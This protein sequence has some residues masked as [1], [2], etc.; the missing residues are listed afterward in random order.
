M[1]VLYS[2]ENDPYFGPDVASMGLYDKSLDID[3]K[4]F[5]TLE[6]GGSRAYCGYYVENWYEYSP[7]AHGKL[8]NKADGTFTYTPNE[9][10]SGTDDSF[11]YSAEFFNCNDCYVEGVVTIVVGEPDLLVS[12]AN[13]L[14]SS[15][16]P[17]R[18]KKPPR[19]SDDVEEI[20]LAL[21]EAAAEQEESLEEGVDHTT[22]AVGEGLEAL[23]E[24]ADDNNNQLLS[25]TLSQLRQEVKD[26]NLDAVPDVITSLIGDLAEA[27]FEVW[28]AMSLKMTPRFIDSCV[29]LSGGKVSPDT[30]SEAVQAV[31]QLDEDHPR[32]TEV[33]QHLQEAVNI[34]EER[35]SAMED[36]SNLQYEM[37]GMIITGLEYVGEE[38][39]A[40]QFAADSEACGN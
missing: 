12:E 21:F 11:I 33:L 22:E 16:R 4:P 26:G 13:I 6:D 36:S 25:E 34:I 17:A 9:V 28:I 20:I 1:I 15:K 24:F 31:D 18:E 5:M 23:I 37:I 8:E 19:E 7:P 40:E 27:P 38:D 39:L 29:T 35:N 10:G 32:K 2:E 3:V 14:S 30:I